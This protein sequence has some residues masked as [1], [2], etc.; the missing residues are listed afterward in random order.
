MACDHPLKLYRSYNTGKTYGGEKRYWLDSS[1]T[2]SCM[3][4]IGCRIERERQWTVR[5]LHEA[6]QYEVENNHFITLTYSPEHCPADYSLEHRDFQLFMKRLRKAIAPR[7]VRFFMCGEYGEKDSRP[8]FHAILFGL[9]IPDLRGLYRNQRGDQVFTSDWLAN[10]WGKG[11]I[12]IG[13]VNETTAA[14]VSGYLTKDGSRQFYKEV[15]SGGFPHPVTGERVFRKP[16]YQCMSTNPGIAAD[17]IDEFYPEVFRDDAVVVSRKTP[18]GRKNVKAIP[19]KYY[20][21][22][23][24]RIDP[25]FALR[26]KQKR[27]DARE[28]PEAKARD[29]DSFRSRRAEARAARLKTFKRGS[30]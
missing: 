27:S 19:P 7:K 15:E 4:C 18:K 30:L 25:D 13:K 6:K 29:C 8:H 21:R 11:F 22:R 1:F 28:T 23:L 12:T 26:V 5:I 10:T 14:Y 20:L 2:V 24:E 16:P 9:P 3:K 17:W